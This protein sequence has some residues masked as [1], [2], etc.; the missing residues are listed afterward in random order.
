MGAAIAAAVAVA[1]LGGV[2][3]VAGLKLLD[4]HLRLRGP[5]PHRRDVVIVGIGEQT[6][7]DLNHPWPFPRAWHARAIEN[8]QA[9][10]PR[11]VGLDILFVEPSIFGAQDDLALATTLAKYDN[12]VLAG[13]YYAEEVVTRRVVVGGIK[14]PVSPLPLGSVG[15]VNTPHDADGFV[16]RIPV[17]MQFKETGRVEG[18]AGQIVK[19]ATRHEGRAQ[20]SSR[21]MLINF[22]G[23]TGSFETVPFHQVLRGEVGAGTFA[24]KIVLIGVTTP[25]LQDVAHTPFTPRA[26]M[27]GVEVH[28]NAVNTLLQGDPLRPAGR[29]LPLLLAALA[30]VAGTLLGAR[31]PPPKSFLLVAGVG[32]AVLV[33]AQVALVWFQ[34]WLEQIPVQAALF[35]S[36]FAVLVSGT[37]LRPSSSPSSEGR[38]A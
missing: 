32:L 30:A 4:R 10:K 29:E 26:L 36:Y 21:E 35:G 5:I 25:A 7:T 37:P 19:V 27:P 22:R 31:F 23:P 9:A 13:M 17:Y 6:F 38:G 33:G 8:I 11:A 12:V 15:L 28:A 16:R 24:G 3:E 18:F 14:L 34:V 1:Y 2:W 20:P